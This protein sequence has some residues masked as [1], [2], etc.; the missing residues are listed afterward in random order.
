M[1]ELA[2]QLRSAIDRYATLDKKYT[3][4]PDEMKCDAV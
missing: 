2:L 1:L 3:L 4:K